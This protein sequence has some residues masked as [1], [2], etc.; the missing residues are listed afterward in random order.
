MTRRRKMLSDRDAPYMQ[1][2]IRQMETQSKS[3]LATWAIDYSEAVLIPLWDRSYPD[4][5]RPISAIHAARE[6]LTGRIKLPEAKKAILQ[7]HEAAQEADCVPAAQAAARAIGQSA[8]IIHS[9]RHC[10]GLPFYG[11][12]AI[13]LDR[14]G[15][16]AEWEF[17]ERQAAEECGRMLEMLRSRSVA[18]EPGPAKIN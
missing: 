12:L 7:C 10:M 15:T 11:A 4:D 8:S 3:T 17:L 2:L 14:L 13:A 18:D 5:S 6:R 1:A 9:A 16:E